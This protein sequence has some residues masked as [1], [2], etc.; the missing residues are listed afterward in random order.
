[1]RDEDGVFINVQLPGE[2]TDMNLGK[3]KLPLKYPQE[4]KIANEK[5]NDLL[6]MR[7]LLFAGG[8]WIEELAERQKLGGL[9]QQIEEEC[10]SSFDEDTWGEN[11]CL[12]REKVKKIDNPQNSLLATKEV[13]QIDKSQKSQKARKASN[14]IQNDIGYAL[15][16][17]KNGLQQIYDLEKTLRAKKS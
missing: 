5:M 6:S 10:V 8:K 15:Q 7:D 17:S 3:V 14:G 11:N 1:M 12:L 4:I 2:K 9:C 16:K 13:K